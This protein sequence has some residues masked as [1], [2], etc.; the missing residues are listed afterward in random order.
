MVS[1]LPRSSTDGAEGIIDNV[2]QKA[3]FWVHHGTTRINDR[4][5]LMLNR[6][7]EGFHGKLTPS[8]WAKIAK[9]SQATATRDIENLIEH[10]IL[11]KDAGG[12][13]STSY[14]LAPTAPDNKG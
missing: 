5:R 6:L 4:Q 1:R 3:A 12:G 9:V 8:K 14:S 11:Q 10:G 7:L 2:L 13:R